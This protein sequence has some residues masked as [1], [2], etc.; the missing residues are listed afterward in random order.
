M[1]SFKWNS[2]TLATSC[3][4]L[5]H[6]KRLW[7]WA[8]LGA[9]AEVMTEVEMA[10]WH[11]ELDGREFEWTPGVGDGQGGLACFSS[12]DRRV[13]HHWATEFNWTER[14]STKRKRRQQRMRLLDGIP[15]SMDMNLS[16]LQEIV[17]DRWSYILQSTGSQRVR[18]D[19]T[20]D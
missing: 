19:L 3:E 13:G 16:K 11:H 15:Y 10:E 4:E 17:K 20:T 5:T 6:W 8:G 18:R 1:Y 14:P 12:W 9:G 7:C 2:S